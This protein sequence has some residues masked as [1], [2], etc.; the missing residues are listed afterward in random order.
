MKKIF[1]VF[2]FSLILVPGKTHA[3]FD[4]ASIIKEGIKKVIVS[5]DLKIQRLQN[6]TIWLQNAQ[7][8]IENTMAKAKLGEISEWVE[9]QKTLYKDYFE[10]LWK[11]KNVI[12]YYK[13]I[14]DITAKQVR[15]VEAYKNAYA[16][17]KQDNH[18]TGKEI[19]YMGKVYSGILE[20]SVQNL[21]QIF[22]A[23]NS[24]ALQISDAR[25]LEMIDAAANAIEQN[26]T[27]LVKFNRQNIMLSMQRSK[28]LSE[29]NTIKI[30]YGIK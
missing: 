10:E 5:V 29:V 25:R 3:Q 9:K 18:F 19:E 13:R 27:D 1:I 8:A 24:F 16:L 11:V 4:I 21:D 14:K 7:K 28:D 20:E 17:F 2:I 26:Y 23:I 15:L 6:K 12:S 22:L 30:L